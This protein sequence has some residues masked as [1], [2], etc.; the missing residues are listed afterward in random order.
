MR[1]RASVCESVTLF[2]TFEEGGQVRETPLTH[3]STT[4]IRSAWF[5]CSENILYEVSKCDFFVVKKTVA[6][7]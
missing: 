5:F 3:L 2:L 4:N 7:I 6:I 1:F